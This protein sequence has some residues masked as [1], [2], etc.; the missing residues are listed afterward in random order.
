MLA[1]LLLLLLPAAAEAQNVLTVV[2]DPAGVCRPAAASA[3][4]DAQAGGRNLELLL[5]SAA[6]ATRRVLVTV[7]QQGRPRALS[8][9]VLEPAHTVTV[10]IDP[11]TGILSGERVMLRSS[12][13]IRRP[14]NAR[15]LDSARALTLEVVRRCGGS[16][17]AAR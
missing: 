9:H 7:D 1:A 5:P 2:P 8:D 12:A 10:R 11:E 3:D 16:G 6:Q 15:A 4:S 13:T 17:R 14:L